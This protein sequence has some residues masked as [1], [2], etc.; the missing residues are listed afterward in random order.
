MIKIKISEK[1]KDDIKQLV[2]EAISGSSK[3]AFLNVLQDRTNRETLRIS[4]PDLYEMLYNENDGSVSKGKI[5][6]ILFA[7]R[8]GLEKII[9]KLGKI[10]NDQIKRDITEKIF[11]YESFSSR[12]IFKKIIW[13]M[14]VSVCPYCNRQYVTTLENDNV[15]AQ[16]DHYYA[17]SEYPY[18]AL[19]INNLIPCCGVCNQMKGEADMQD[20]N[21]RMFYPYEEEIGYDAYWAVQI[22]EESDFVKVWSGKSD[23]FSIVLKMTKSADESFEKKMTNQI[24][25]LNLDKLYQSHK[26]YVIDIIRVHYINSKSRI[27][28][29]SSILGMNEKEVERLKYMNYLNKDDWGKRPLA[30]LTH[31]IVM[32]LEHH[33]SNS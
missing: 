23:K 16:V 31:D 22:E 28:D 8:K 5:N 14:N 32:Q 33:V 18:L 10:K 11:C 1:N 21:H 12:Q 24:R 15:R 26:D 17:K 27:K 2:L 25:R 30:K 20:D 7:D 19:S 29:I 3:K 6:G 4:F 13:H 9:S